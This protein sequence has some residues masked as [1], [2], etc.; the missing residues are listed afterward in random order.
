MV[1]VRIEDKL[2]TESSTMIIL[3]MLVLCMMC[4]NIASASDYF[5][6]NTKLPVCKFCSHFVIP[7]QASSE[8]GKCSLFGVKNVVTGR[9]DYD[10][11]SKII[12][13]EE[14][15]GTLGKLWVSEETN[16]Y[17]RKSAIIDFCENPLQYFLTDG[18]VYGLM[19]YCAGLIKFIIIIIIFLMM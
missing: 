11:A 9:I 4:T 8:Y 5:I 1:I 3:L 7:K 15:C 18:F 12:D 16:V 10:L 19:Y 17:L 14:K 2:S 6:K 13:D